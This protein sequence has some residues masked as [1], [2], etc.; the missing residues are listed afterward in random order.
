MRK[1]YPATDI[2]PLDLF[3]S[4]RN[5][6]IWDLKINHLGRKYDVVGLLNFEEGKSQSL[7]L[8]WKELG[9]PEGVPVQVYDFWNNEY[10]G[11]WEAGIALIIPPTSCRVLTL[12]PNTGDIQ[13]IST[14]RHITQGWTDLADIRYIPDRKYY[15]GTSH[16]IGNDPYQLT[17]TYPRGT[18]FKVETVCIK[19]DGQGIKVRVADH[20]GWSTVLFTSPLSEDI[21]WEVT[22]EPAES[23]SYK[24]RD[25]GPATAVRL[26]LDGIDLSWNPQYYLN[27]GYQ[28][29]LDGLVQGYTPDCSFPLR[30]LDPDRT[31]LAE[32]R[33]V[34]DDGT[35]NDRPAPSGVNQNRPAPGVRF[36][37]A[38]MLPSEY[39]LTDLEPELPPQ[40]SFNRPLTFTGHKFDNAITG[41][42]NTA[43]GYDLKGLFTHFSA[44]V[45]VD[46]A[47]G[48][49]LANTTVEFVVSGD[50][51]ELWRSGP[52]KKSDP[53]KTAEVDMSGI[54]ILSL[55]VEGPQATGYRRGGIVAGWV[56]A[57]V[58]R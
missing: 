1:I 50:G 54:S 58:K 16:V 34:W 38:E 13:L 3:P 55:K 4:K 46:D 48:E 17:F 51:K 47:T 30:G 2:R 24:T 21:S 56:D 36:K 39:R 11:A 10:L 28:V 35:I 19:G 6:R 12:M 37:I 57:V 20:Q 42:M 25:P 5:K 45:G 18:Y 8:D 22:F 7:K 15:E 52:M 44:M 31:Y 53:A 26:G 43:T 32:V 33:T 23:Y 41:A 14:N 40:F 27:S 29:Y 9:L 49:Q